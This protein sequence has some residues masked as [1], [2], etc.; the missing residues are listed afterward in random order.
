MG[1]APSTHL[2][3]IINQVKGQSPWTGE[4]FQCT[5]KMETFWAV[6]QKFWVIKSISNHPKTPKNSSH[7][8][9]HIHNSPSQFFRKGWQIVAISLCLAI[10]HWLIESLVEVLF[11]PRITTTRFHSH[12]FLSHFMDLINYCFRPALSTQ[13]SKKGRQEMGMRR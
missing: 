4:F 3:V 2:S 10:R 1:K 8:L 11:S 7:S 12:G 9:I 6:H 5:Q 13:K